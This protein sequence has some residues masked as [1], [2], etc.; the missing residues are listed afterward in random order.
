MSTSCLYTKIY[1]DSSN[2]PDSS[3]YLLWMFKEA[4]VI[5]ASSGTKWVKNP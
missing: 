5:I 2:K 4:I 3:S 1:K